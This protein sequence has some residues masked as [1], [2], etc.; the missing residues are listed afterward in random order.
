M[1]SSR[2][3]YIFDEGR[4]ASLVVDEVTPLEESTKKWGAAVVGS[5]STA[6]R[7]MPFWAPTDNVSLLLHHRC[8]NRESSTT[9]DSL[10]CFLFDSRW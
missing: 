2:S 7:T 1:G 3:P 4:P 10:N 9:G 5:L 6:K 8:T